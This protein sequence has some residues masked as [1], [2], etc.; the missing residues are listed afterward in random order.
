MAEKD[1]ARKGMPAEVDDLRGG[2][3]QDMQMYEGAF[4]KRM[5]D[6]HRFLGKALVHVGHEEQ[7]EA[8]ER[9]FCYGTDASIIRLGDLVYNCKNAQLRSDKTAPR[10]AVRF[11]ISKQGDFLIITVPL[12]LLE[13]DVKVDIRYAYQKWEISMLASECVACPTECSIS[14][15]RREI[16]W[17][18]QTIAQ[19]NRTLQLSAGEIPTLRFHSGSIARGVRLIQWWV[20]RRSRGRPRKEPSQNARAIGIATAWFMQQKGSR[21]AVRLYY[22]SSNSSAP[23]RIRDP[24]QGLPP[25]DSAGLQHGRAM[26][27]AAEQ[28]WNYYSHKC[29]VCKDGSIASRGDTLYVLSEDLQPQRRILV[30]SG[31]VPGVRGMTVIELGTTHFCLDIMG[32]QVVSARSGPTVTA[33]R[34]LQRRWRNRTLSNDKG[35]RQEVELFYKREALTRGKWSKVTLPQTVWRECER[36]TA[37]YKAT[38]SWCEMCCTRHCSD[39]GPC[40]TPAGTRCSGIIKKMSI[41]H[42][43]HIMN[44]GDKLVVCARGEDPNTWTIVKV[45]EAGS[46]MQAPQAVVESEA[47]KARRAGAENLGNR[48]GKEGTAQE[49]RIHAKRRNRDATPEEE[50]RQQLQWNN[51]HSKPWEGIAEAVSQDHVGKGDSFFE[52]VAV[53]IVQSHD[54]TRGEKRKVR[55]LEFR[56]ASGWDTN[57]FQAQ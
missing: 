43:K 36:C 46:S 42:K 15:C 24:C 28:E 53:G 9:N 33:V 52:A 40:R 6:F 18:W 50:K 27:S 32:D 1:P 54:G 30:V 47:S 35:K 17:S 38:G 19:C 51:K 2:G 39:C 20:R 11:A 29:A 12:A 25:K 55:V 13:R 21:E 4:T 7:M 22:E 49:L 8:M 26:R 56:G 14:R 45:N 10:A 57:P 5:R 37:I 41:E 23:G 16:P 48:G 31:L 34:E 3:G 44:P